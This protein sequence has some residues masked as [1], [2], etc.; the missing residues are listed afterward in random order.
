VEVVGQQLHPDH[1]VV[2]CR[3]VEPDDWCHSCGCPGG[4]AR[5]RAAPTGARPASAGPTTILHVRIHRYRCS[6]CGQVWRQ[7]TT[8]GTPLGF[9]NLTNYITRSCS[10]LAASDPDYT[11]FCDEPA[12]WK[13]SEQ[14]AA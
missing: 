9:R 5:Q 3:M 1:A 13:S 2:L 4:A 14:S 10:T 7:H 6:D 12:N 11:L 8:D